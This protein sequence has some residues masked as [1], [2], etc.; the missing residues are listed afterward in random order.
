MSL[1][2]QPTLRKWLMRALGDLGG[3]ASKP[4]V[5]KRMQ[6]IFGD[7][8]TEDDWKAMPSNKEV[9][10]QNRT[11]W[12]RQHMVEEG[13]LKSSSE[14]GIWELSESGWRAYRRLWQNPH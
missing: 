4:R 6:D 5:L 13:L 9:K 3:S 2:Q 10:W 14:H 12:E 8:L 7:S 1:T 11:A